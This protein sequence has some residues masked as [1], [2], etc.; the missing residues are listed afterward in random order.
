MRREDLEDCYSQA[1]LELLTRARKGSGFESPQH[2]S[3][4]LE[5]KFAS[6]V[7]D[8]HRALGGRSA[9]EAALA[10]AASID[11]HEGAVGDLA[12]RRAEVPDQ[13][14]HRHDLSRLREVAEDLTP[15][16][17]LV[18]ACQVGLDMGC[19]EFCRRFGWSA[20]KF[21]KVSQRGRAKLRALVGEYQQGERCLQLEPAVLAYLAGA[22]GP[23]ERH[24]VLMHLDNCQSCAAM[25]RE[26]DLASR[27]VAAVVPSPVWLAPGAAK[28]GLLLAVV[29][30]VL[31]AGASGPG[32]AVSSGSAG[33]VG[34]GGT[35]GGGGAALGAG[36]SVLGAGGMKLGVAALCF[37]G[38]AGGY[39]ACERAGLLP[40]LAPGGSS[41][42]HHVVQHRVHPSS[43]AVS[44]G[45]VPGAR[46]GLLA[47]ASRARAPLGAT[48]ASGSGRSARG[49]SA[50]P[51]RIS[52]ATTAMR[53]FGL[54]G[55]SAASATV[56]RRPPHRRRPAPRRASARVAARGPLTPSMPG[57]AVGPAH[58][59][60]PSPSQGP[61]ARRAARAEFGP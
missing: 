19:A 57:P 48:R 27:R 32:H 8:R 20:E 45:M 10:G 18:L 58:R 60:A 23:N 54:G 15:D 2:V 28:L 4:A 49:R 51:Y 16:Q 26:L 61:R 14:S 31:G 53:E 36:G 50:P 29:R 40:P 3:N 1:T 22:A 55:A 6:R 47:P 33:G 24:R 34:A 56:R 35:L 59:P 13:V 39:A 7:K 38:A 21:R 37:A 25:V 5:Q 12:D 44:P 46:V 52:R 17:R 42:G 9:L 43:A 41:A 30:R 11:D